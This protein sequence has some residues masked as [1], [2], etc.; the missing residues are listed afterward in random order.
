MS[1]FQPPVGSLSRFTEGEAPIP[2]EFIR[3]PPKSAKV[4]EMSP[5][6][7]PVGSLSRFTEGEAPIPRKQVQ[8]ALAAIS[9]EKSPEQ[10]FEESVAQP[11]KTSSFEKD[12]PYIIPA[13]VEN[14]VYQILS[15]S[16]PSQG[17]GESQPVY[18]I[19]SDSSPSLTPP[20]YDIS[21]DSS[22]LSQSILTQRPLQRSISVS[23]VASESPETIQQFISERTRVDSPIQASP[24]A[25]SILNSPQSFSLSQSI[26]RERPLERSISVSPVSFE[27]SEPVQQFLS[28]RIRSSRAE[29]QV[30]PLPTAESVL[31]SPPSRPRQMFPLLEIGEELRRECSESTR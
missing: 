15:P 9:A 18:D 6:Q 5:F 11:K 30:Q 13:A 27:S 21:S 3:P 19:S 29:L 16:K 31:N 10:S 8:F 1:P 14:P 2:M 20:V 17:K 12:V 24:T 23:P 26:S 7:P 22:S 25:E 4:I 28:E